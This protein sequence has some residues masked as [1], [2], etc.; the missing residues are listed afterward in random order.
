M[1]TGALF[2]LGIAYVS[3]ADGHV[4]VD[5]AFANFPIR[6]QALVN[7]IGLLLIAP[8]VLWLCIGLWD[9]LA[10]AW[11][12]GERSGESIWNPV[13]WPARVTYFL[14]FVLF[15]MQILADILKALLSL[16]TGKHF[17]DAA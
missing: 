2:V 6:A 8:L 10:R 17:E 13:V 3:Q 14:G 16:L 1:Q 5:L 4:R 15:A 11:Q 12:S 7:L 9:F